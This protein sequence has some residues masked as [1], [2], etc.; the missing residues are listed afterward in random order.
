[1]AQ[2]YWVDLSEQHLYLHAQ[3]GL[4]LFRRI[5][6]EV[7]NQTLGTYF[8]D[9][10]LPISISPP[11]TLAAVLDAEFSDIQF[12]CAPK[13][14]RRLQAAAKLRGL[15]ILENSLAGERTQPSDHDLRGYISDV[16][17]GLNW[18]DLFPGIATLN[19]E[20]TGTGFS[21]SLRLT[22]SEG[23]PVRLVGED[24]P[25]AT[26][27]GVRRVN[28]LDYYSLGMAQLSTHVGLTQPKCLAVVRSLKL[29]EDD[30]YFK[31]IRI[32]SQQHKRYSRKTIKRIQDEL[33]GLD[34]AEVWRL[35]KPS[36][37]LQR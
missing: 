8:P 16:Q 33:P 7:Y 6:G 24:D 32:G 34:M 22:K 30:E 35:Y 1:A 9:R 2:H 14:R 17:N 11:Q 25:N 26:V 5:L 31:I 18:T 21:V 23:E 28:E 4:T 13:S 10:V 12:L 36:G 19:L 27:V 3:A 15:A 29:Q 20:T 37:R